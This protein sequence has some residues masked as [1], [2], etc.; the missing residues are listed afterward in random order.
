MNAGA[1]A[2]VSATAIAASAAKVSMCTCIFFHLE[3]A[4]LIIDKRIL[5]DSR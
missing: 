4:F 3:A 5:E 2:N 1:I